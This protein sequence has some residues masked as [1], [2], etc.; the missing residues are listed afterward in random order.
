VDKLGSDRAKLRQ[1][2]EQR[3]LGVHVPGARLRDLDVDLPRAASGPAGPGTVR[4]RYSF[5]D[6]QLAVRSG[7]EMKLQPTFFRSQPGRRFATEPQRSTTLVL[8]FDVPFRMTATVELPHAANLVDPPARQDGV[9]ARKGGYRFL[10]ERSLRPG[11]PDVLVLRR[12]S[13]L[14]LMRV[15]PQEYAGVAADL[16]RVD[17][18]EQQEIRIG[19]RG[20]RPADAG[21]R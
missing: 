7:H 19:L 8:G 4:V 6:P 20:R 12:E 17:G 3:W 5:V 2:F 1:D 13:A 16:R 10:E 9:I 11:S 15:P 18:L 21:T 14:P